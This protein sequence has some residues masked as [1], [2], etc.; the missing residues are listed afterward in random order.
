MKDVV[1]KGT[2]DTLRQLDKLKVELEPFVNALDKLDEFKDPS[3]GPNGPPAKPEPSDPVSNEPSTTRASSSSSSSSCTLQT[4]SNCNIACTARATT[5]VGGQNKRAEGDN[6]STNC[7]APITRC[8]ATG[9]TSVSTITSTATIPGHVCSPN[10]ST[11]AKR[12]L[13]TTNPASF[14]HPTAT[15]SQ[16]SRDILQPVATSSASSGNNTITINRTRNP[17][18]ALDRRYF[19]HWKGDGGPEWIPSI[20]QGD[21]VS[22]LRY[23]WRQIPPAHNLNIYGLAQHQRDYGFMTTGFSFPFLKEYAQY[24][25]RGLYGCTSVVIISPKRVFMS[26]IWE[27]PTL[28]FAEDDGDHF[29]DYI[30]D[31]LVNGD[32]SMLHGGLNSFIGPGGDFEDSE[33]N[34]VR[35]FIVTAKRRDPRT[36][37]WDGTDNVNFPEAINDIKQMLK[38]V[39]GDRVSTNTRTLKY[40]PRSDDPG[41]QNEYGKVLVRYDPNNDA[42]QGIGCTGQVAAVQLWFEETEPIYQTFWF[43]T[44]E[45]FD[46]RLLPSPILSIG[47]NTGPF[48]T[49]SAIESV[50][51]RGLLKK[52]GFTSTNEKEWKEYENVVRRYMYR[53]Q[54]NQACPLPSRSLSASSVSAS[55]VSASSISMNSL[56]ESS[57]TA[58]SILSSQ[59]SSS[60]PKPTDPT[61]F[62]TSVVPSSTPRSTEVPSTPSTPTSSIAPAPPPPMASRAVSIILQYIREKDERYNTWVFHETS[63]GVKAD[64]CNN[65]KPV[66]DDIPTRWFDKTSIDTPPWPWGTFEIPVLFGEKGCKYLSDGTN[67]G[68]LHCPSLNGQTIGCKEDAEKSLTYPEQCLYSGNSIRTIH[69]VAYYARLSAHDKEIGPDKVRDGFSVTTYNG[70]GHEVISPVNRQIRVIAVEI[71]ES[72]GV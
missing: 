65:S 54:G 60:S 50:R 22:W 55:S 40:V 27:W 62:E 68:I 38:A 1:V 16:I 4:V 18:K 69:R 17:I 51:I 13:Y 15:S 61:T 64:P 23:E 20:A 19:R 9:I 45:Q 72:R 5:T 3:K 53:R 46:Q 42:L 14:G 67:P 41:L 6:C 2:S 28:T 56:T 48:I 57:V 12:G 58:S 24:S 29:N 49:P 8:G 7:G 39:L 31:Q 47:T 59:E 43:P 21:F 10:F 70:P 34:E 35:A 52:R 44:E 33:E 37:M 36:G 66:H 32:G 63:I 11:R 71:F 25:V 30:Y 26:H